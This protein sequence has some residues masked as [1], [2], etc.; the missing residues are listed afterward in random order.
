[1]KMEK[2]VGKN[3]STGLHFKK[4]HMKTEGVLLY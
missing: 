4:I 3:E 2:P 1:M